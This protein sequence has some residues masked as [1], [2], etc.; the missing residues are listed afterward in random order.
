M[1]NSVVPM[2]RRKRASQ[3]YIATSDGEDNTSTF[4]K[5]R[6]QTGQGNQIT[7]RRSEPLLALVPARLK[8]SP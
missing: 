3:S 8:C 5:Q 1:L 2:N 4:S 6:L 7:K